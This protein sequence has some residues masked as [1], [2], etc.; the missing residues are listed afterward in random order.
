MKTVLLSP[1][2]DGIVDNETP[3]EYGS[4]N[5]HYDLDLVVSSHEND[6]PD[7][8]HKQ[9]M[10]DAQELQEPRALITYTTASASLHHVPQWTEEDMLQI[11]RIQDF[12]DISC[13][14]C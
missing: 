7:T 2:S 4:D 9:T 6:I 3:S 8:K 10:E 12:T 11:Y 13:F 14:F 5:T 1:G